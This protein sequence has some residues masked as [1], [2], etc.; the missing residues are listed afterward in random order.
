VK[1]GITL[2]EDVFMQYTLVTVEWSV[3][4]IALEDRYEIVLDATYETDVPAPVL[5]IEP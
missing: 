2:N 3:Q 5:V 1:P 4:E